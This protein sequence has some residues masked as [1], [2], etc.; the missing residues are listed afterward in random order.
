MSAEDLG[1]SEEAG[2]LAFWQWAYSDLR[3]N[4]IRP[5]LAEFLVGKAL[6][7]LGPYR[8]EWVAWDFMF[9]GK[10]IEVKSAGYV[11]SWDQPA[12]SNITFSIAAARNA[13]GEDQVTLIGPGRHADIY[14][15]CVHTELDRELARRHDLEAWTF[16]VVPTFALEAA[17]GSQ[18]SL[19]L[20]RLS[21]LATPS[22][23]GDLKQS[24][25]AA[26]VGL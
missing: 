2:L 16:Y 5:M 12:P 14:V 10:K 19:S 13:Y 25:T 15:F 18:K 1:V 21:K 3:S 17:A 6:G 26:I 9:D 7:C 11:Q 8:R 20:A 22:T 23:W 4:T 24:V